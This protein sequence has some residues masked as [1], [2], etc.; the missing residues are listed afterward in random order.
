MALLRRN[1][2]LARLLVVDDEPSL[3]RA[4][5]VILRDEGHE[6][7]TARNGAEALA[8]IAET[9]PD[10]IVS[11]IRMPVMDGYALAARL[12]A[13][14][15]TKLLPIIFLTAKGD[16]VDRIAGFRLGVDA[17]IPKPFEPDELVAVI[18][19]ILDRVQRTH[20]EITKLIGAPATTDVSIVAGDGLTEAEARV[21]LAVARGLNN[22]EIAAEFQVSMRTVENH[23]SHIYAKKRFSNRVEIAR[24]V[25]DRERTS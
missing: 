20:S 17:Y 11:D 22:K 25:L 9:L 15:R 18:A 21:A 3:L 4:V 13:V 1:I 19:N 14:P 2:E 8:R 5:S 24:Y 10:L 12:R 6:V 23:I 7:A 16:T